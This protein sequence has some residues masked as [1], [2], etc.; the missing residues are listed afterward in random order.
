MIINYLK[1]NFFCNCLFERV[2]NKFY[3]RLEKD[4]VIGGIYLI[5]Y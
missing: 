1:K 3:K 2:F 4:I 5:F